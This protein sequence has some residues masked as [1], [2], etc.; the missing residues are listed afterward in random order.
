MLLHD[1]AV[2]KDFLTVNGKASISALSDKAGAHMRL[3]ASS[4]AEM[5]LVMLDGELVPA[6]R[7]PALGTGN[8]DTLPPT[9]LIAEGQTTGLDV[10]RESVK[11]SSTGKTGTMNF[12]HD[13][14]S[15]KGNVVLRWG[16]GAP[17]LFPTAIIKDF[18]SQG[19]KTIRKCRSASHLLA[20]LWRCTIDASTFWRAGAYRLPRRLNTDCSSFGV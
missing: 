15:A 19:W 14:T 8:G 16:R 10:A 17:Y 7:S 11:G 13:V 6:Y 18:K 12:R 2:L 20:R 3:A 5:S 9:G 4:V 1:K